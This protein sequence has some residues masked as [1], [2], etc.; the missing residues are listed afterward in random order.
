MNRLN[1]TEFAIFI[2]LMS[3]LLLK[4]VTNRDL[5]IFTAAGVT[6]CGGRNTSPRTY[7]AENIFWSFGIKEVIFSIFSNRVQL[8]PVLGGLNKSKFAIFIYLLWFLL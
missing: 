7:S 1:K 4:D 5:F 8:K 3:S 6:P 2:S